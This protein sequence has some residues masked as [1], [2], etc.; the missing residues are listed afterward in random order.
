[1]QNS[2]ILNERKTQLKFFK[3]NKI[4]E[5]AGKFDYKIKFLDEVKN[6]FLKKSN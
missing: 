3:S 5:F 1:M 6:L 2:K 4:L